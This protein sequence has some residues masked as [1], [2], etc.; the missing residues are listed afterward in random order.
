MQHRNR[1]KTVRVPLSL[2]PATNSVLEALAQVG[3]FGKNKAE[4]GTTIIRH[5]IWDNQDKLAQ[6]GIQLRENKKRGGPNPPAQR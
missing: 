3:I 5:W 1:T 4:A 6:Q 2:D